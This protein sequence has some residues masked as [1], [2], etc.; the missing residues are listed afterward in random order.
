MTDQAILTDDDR[1]RRRIEIETEQAEREAA[2]KNNNFLQLTRTNIPDLL[3]LAKD[4]PVGL[5]IMGQML[6]RMNRMNAIVISQDT[7]ATI[8]GKNKRTIIR[9]IQY[10]KANNWIDV[11]KIGTA[12]AYIVNSE[13][14]W[15]GP[16]DE[17]HAA[18]PAQ[19]IAAEKEQKTP[20]RKVKLKHFPVLYQDEQLTLI[21]EQNQQHDLDI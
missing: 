18:F 1:E 6:Q 16:R 14:F 19:V 13:V 10:L 20:I 7:L 2:K 3:F 15:M 9:A 21:G 12:N 17:R 4:S 5:E 11:V 8:T